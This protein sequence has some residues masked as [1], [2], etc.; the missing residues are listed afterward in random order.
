VGNFLTCEVIMKP[1]VTPR[2]VECE[3]R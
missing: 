2:S 3:S 1:D